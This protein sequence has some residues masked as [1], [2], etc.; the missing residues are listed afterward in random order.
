MIERTTKAVLLSPRVDI[1]A[2]AIKWGPTWGQ[3]KKGFSWLASRG[4]PYE[5]PEYQIGN[6]FLRDDDTEGIPV[7]YL[8]SPRWDRIPV[9]VGHYIVWYGKGFYD[10][11][12]HIAVFDEQTYKHLFDADEPLAEFEIEELA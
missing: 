5:F 1:T 2:E 9:R 4:I 10:G 8:Y 7:L 6:A 11:R 12:S 3:M